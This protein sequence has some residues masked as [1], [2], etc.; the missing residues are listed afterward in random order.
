MTVDLLN[1]TMRALWWMHRTCV[2]PPPMGGPDSQLV[3]ACDMELHCTR[4]G[5]LRCCLSENIAHGS[6]WAVCRY[7]CL[8]CKC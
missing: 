2:Q 4:A 7:C 5:S 1:M 8:Y 3:L 6:V